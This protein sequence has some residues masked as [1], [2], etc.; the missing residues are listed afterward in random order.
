MSLLKV[1]ALLFLS[2]T[3]AYSTYILIY[4]EDSLL[5][6]DRETI[7]TTSAINQLQVT[8]YAYY[9]CRHRALVFYFFILLPL[10]T[11]VFS[12]FWPVSYA[13]T[14]NR[15]VICDAGL[16]S[17]TV[18]GLASSP[19]CIAMTPVLLQ[20]KQKNIPIPIQTDRQR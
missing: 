9:L 6:L 1:L 16:D 7:H 4:V 13:V 12:L 14:M 3:T 18:S 15:F 10:K 17:A 19:A 2:S 11:Y 20:L 8:V 5:T